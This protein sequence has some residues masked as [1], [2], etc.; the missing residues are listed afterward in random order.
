MALLFENETCGR[1]GGS[2]NYSYCQRY[3]TTCFKCSGVKA[4]LTKRGTAAQAYYRSLLSKPV[5]ELKPGM[6]IED[7]GVT[8]GG[9]LF[10]QWVTI[11]EIKEDTTLYNGA[12]RPDYRNLECKS[13]RGELHSICVPLTQVFRVAATVEQKKAALALALTYQASL[14]K[15]G[16]PRKS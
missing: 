3:G 5:S 13:R 1:C 15:Q 4:V 2:G 16:K 10:N 6:I 9:D 14:T 12:L 8:F 7:L 11:L